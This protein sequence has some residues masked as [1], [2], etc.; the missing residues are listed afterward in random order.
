MHD[1]IASQDILKQAIKIA[2]KN[3]LK[4]ITKI[5]VKLGKIVEH[6]QEIMPENLAF[7]FE[8]VKK[9][10]IAESAKLVVKKVPGKAVSI[11]EVQGEK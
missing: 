2:E 5:T 4:K 8:L 3:K 11:A 1:L 7:N 10:T 6:N 9:N